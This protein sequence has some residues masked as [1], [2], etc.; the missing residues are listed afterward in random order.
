M[1]TV[2]KKKKGHHSW[3]SAGPVCIMILGKKSIDIWVSGLL[4]LFVISSV[5]SVL[6][7]L[8]LLGLRC[9]DLHTLCHLPAQQGQKDLGTGLGPHV[10]PQAL[11][12][13]FWLMAAWT[14]Q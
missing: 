3:V 11:A 13:Q 6:T 8:S 7:A 2:Q 1:Q 10:R 14:V 5:L 4:A 9:P 12:L